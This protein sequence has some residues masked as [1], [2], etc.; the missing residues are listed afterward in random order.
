MK[1]KKEKRGGKEKVK[2]TWRIWF[3]DDV[4]YVSTPYHKLISIIRRFVFLSILLLG[5]YGLLVMFKGKEAKE[6]HL[7]RNSDVAELSVFTIL[8]NW[9][10]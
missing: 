2:C 8:R 5:G 1:S 10:S 9:F 7:P 3:V 6:P 4:I